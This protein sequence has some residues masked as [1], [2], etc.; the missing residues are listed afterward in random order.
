AV[1]LCALVLLVPLSI[2]GVIAGEDRQN[3]DQRRSWTIA[4]YWG[5]DNNLDGDTETFIDLWMECL[6]TDEVA[7]AVFIDRLELP[8]N[9][10]TVTEEGWVERATPGEVNSSDPQ[11]LADF[12]EYF[13]T[14]PVLDADNYML[15]VQDHGMGYLGIIA[16]DSEP[17]GKAWMSIDGLGCALDLA[18]EATGKKLDIVD[19]DA[20]SMATVEVA[21]ELR[22]KASYLVAS[23]LAVP[24]DGLNY[25]ALLCGLSEEADISPKALACKM[26][27]DYGDWYSAP[28]G[29]Y[30]TLYPYMQDF[31]SLSVIDLSKMDAV[32][33]AFSALSDAILPKD[34]AFANPFNIAAQ[35]YFV[36]MWENNMGCGFTSDVR[37]MFGEIA[38]ALRDSHPTVA[39]LCDDIVSSASDAIV[40][41]WASWRFRGRITGMSV[42]TP[43]SIGIYEVGWD[44]LNRVYG[45]MG[46]DF[47]E[48][49]GWDEVLLTYSCTSKQLGAA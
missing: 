39:A 37:G 15:I 29:T 41:E 27:D 45:D 26:V 35:H 11:V 40:K 46:L 10:S 43:S 21:Y 16:D 2:T 22:G 24:F 47:T 4:M 9:I 7:L 48:D 38:S 14:E 31:A 20:C 25:M 18:Y 19:L 42:F 30:P 44:A 3:E 1:L 17:N 6:T 8:T 13:M 12:I 28:L 5:G 33:D 32:G 23:Q 34:K 49:T 36:A